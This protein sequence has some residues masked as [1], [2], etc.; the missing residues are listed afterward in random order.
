MPTSTVPT[1][2]W[3]KI[4]TPVGLIT[5]PPDLVYRMRLHFDCRTESRASMLWDEPMPNLLEAR[6]VVAAIL[7][8]QKWPWVIR[9]EAVDMRNASSNVKRR[10][11]LTRLNGRP[12]F[13]RRYADHAIVVPAV[14]VIPEGHKPRSDS[15]YHWE[16]FVVGE[17]AVFPDVSVQ[18]V[19]N[20]MSR[21][22]QR[23]GHLD[24]RFCI[25]KGDRGVEVERTV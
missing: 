22:R 12:N 3:P 6:L 10:Y 8:E 1:K 19:H 17:S 21:W 25:T 11:S 4:D 23:H 2:F 20:S 18:A 9:V 5:Y 16:D 15:K 14:P 7:A 13:A 24:W